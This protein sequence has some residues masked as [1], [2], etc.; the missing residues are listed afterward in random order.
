MKGN[1][2]LAC[3]GQTNTQTKKQRLININPDKAE[4]C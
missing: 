1:P 2:N 3:E 4:A